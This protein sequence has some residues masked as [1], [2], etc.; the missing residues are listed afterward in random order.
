MC[1][2]TRAGHVIEAVERAVVQ[3]HL[4]RLG[5][6]HGLLEADL[7]LAL[8]ELVEKRNE[9]APSLA[10]PARRGTNEKESRRGDK[11][12]TQRKQ[13]PEKERT[14]RRT[15]ASKLNPLISAPSASLRLSLSSS[16]WSRLQPDV[17]VDVAAEVGEPLLAGA[18][19]AV[20]EG[21]LH[22]VVLH[23]GVGG[24]RAAPSGMTRT[25]AS[26]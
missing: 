20:D 26:S 10:R 19:E 15:D 5:E 6:R 8:A 17:D 18:L 9:H 24:T 11:Q 25:M 16:P 1:T 14:P 4:Q 3:A 12:S 21:L 23:V 2:Q 7:H 22:H 13:G